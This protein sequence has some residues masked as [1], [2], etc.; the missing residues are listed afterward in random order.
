MEV[1]EKV[2]EVEDQVTHLQLVHHKDKME[3]VVIIQEDLKLIH[4]VEVVVLV[5]Q[6]KMVL[7][8]Q[9]QQHN[10]LLQVEMV[11]LFQQ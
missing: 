2:E 9:D 4:Q 1:E 6:V 11:N 8:V 10:N 7:M 5:M 3:E